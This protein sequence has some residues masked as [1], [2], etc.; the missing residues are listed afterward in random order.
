VGFFCGFGTEQKKKFEKKTVPWGT[1]LG[2]VVT[3]KTERKKETAEVALGGK[4]PGGGGL[5]RKKEE[6]RKEE[7]AKKDPTKVQPKVYS[8]GGKFCFNK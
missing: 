6:P 5:A 7:K 8:R 4:I 1:Y 2:S 3:F